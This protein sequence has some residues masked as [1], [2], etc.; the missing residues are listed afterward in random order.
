MGP[1]ASLLVS[2]AGA[3]GTPQGPELPPE[4]PVVAVYSVDVLGATPNVESDD[5]TP[6][7]Q[8]AIDAAIDFA[9]ASGQTS[10]VQ[11]SGGGEYLLKTGKRGRGHLDLSCASG[12][13]RV[14]LQGNGA[15]VI[16]ETPRLGVFFAQQSKS[17]AIEDLRIDLGVDPYMGGTVTSVDAT[18]RKVVAQ[19][20]PGATALAAFPGYSDEW[21]WLHD[22]EVL[23]RP[24]FGVGSSF[25]AVSRTQ[26]RRGGPVRFTMDPSVRMADFEVG[27]VISF[28]YRRGNNFR[29]QQCEDIEVNG[30]ISLGAGLFFIAT[31][32]VSG[33]RVVDSAVLVKPG[34]VQA[35]NGDGIHLKYCRDVDVEGC[36]FEGLSDDGINVTGTLG[37]RIERCTFTNKRRHAI[38]LDTDVAKYRSRRG[39]IANCVASFN[40][41]S[42]LQHDG[43]DYSGVVVEGNQTSSNNL[44]PSASKVRRS[45]RLVTEGSHRVLTWSDSGTVG[46]SENTAHAEGAHP[47]WS[48]IDVPTPRGARCRI[49]T[50]VAKGPQPWGYLSGRGAIRI[51]ASER[52]APRHDPIQALIDDQLWIPERAGD[53]KIWLRHERTGQYLTAD[54]AS[55][56]A[57]A[58]TPHR[59]DA[60]QWFRFHL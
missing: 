13:G 54:P 10:I 58:W 39:A 11:F 30:V 24:K 56:G 53:G 28:H 49:Q 9:N 7:I 5:D 52:A 3:L 26:D 17:I 4:Q 32:H 27:D 46:L 25:K 21:G 57:L 34:R 59:D 38:A 41:G 18:E 35:T 33:L 60:L 20:F 40:G 48:W 47:F 15:T 1:V 22:S 42:F 50:H 36:Y 8:A 19:P 12:A 37:F 31:S 23:H 44:T 2:F 14:V 51:A 16:V 55:E 45:T 43:G 29:F 6:G